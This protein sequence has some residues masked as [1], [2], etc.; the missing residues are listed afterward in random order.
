MLGAWCSPPRLQSPVPPHPTTTMHPADIARALD[1]IAVLLQLAG[2]SDFRTKAYSNAALAVTD[3]ADRL[4]GLAATG[5]LGQVRGLTG[6]IGEKVRD[7]LATGRM[8]YLDEL[9]AA[10]PPGLLELLRVPGLGP[11]KAKALFDALKP[12]TLA[13]L[14]AA[15]LDGRLAQVKG[16]AA[17][18]TERILAATRFLLSAGDRLRFDRAMRI[19][20]ALLDPIAMLPGVRRAELTGELRRRKEV[21]ERVTILVACD[22]PAKIFNSVT[23]LDAVVTLGERSADRLRL[24]A[25]I[26][27]RT[28]SLTL[29]A[30]IVAVTAG[31]PLRLVQET[32]PAEHW[33]ALVALAEGGDFDPDAIEN[34]ADVYRQLGLHPVPPECREWPD[35]IDVAR[36]GPFP[37]LLRDSDILG[38]FH[39]HTT[40]SDGNATLDE[41]ATAAG[42][43]GYGYF[44]LGD[45]SQSLTVANGLTPERVRSQWEQA[46]EWNA[47]HPRVRVFRGTECDILSGGRLDFDDDLLAGF[48]YV[49]GSVHSLFQLPEAEQTERVCR[50]LQHPSLTMLG[51]PTGRLLLRREGYAI[52]LGAVIDAAARHGKMIEINAQPDRLDLSWEWCRVAKSKG[53]PLVINPDAH[54]T[55]DLEKVAFGVNVARRAGLTAADVFNTLDADAVA[56]EF[57]RRRRA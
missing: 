13:E 18:S 55:A 19:G 24:L 48:D 7:A 22:D 56:A 20:V 32:G 50:A 27:Y 41:M 47:N 54:S 11:K 39:N 43:L 21:V 15:C 45:H 31:Y 16:F 6:A 8:A 42:E 35:A 1:E 44:G 34:E 28:G 17:K 46:R 4:V 52:D 33:D 12:N 14:E 37:E 36:A 40:S 3:V 25:S 53:V 5:R 38:V 51:H 30:E 57:A 49:V 9:R 10:T 23:G 26:P 2:E 29:T